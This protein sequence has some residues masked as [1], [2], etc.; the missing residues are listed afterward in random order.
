MGVN[1]QGGGDVGMAENLLDHLRRQAAGRHFGGGGVAAGVRCDALNAQLLHQ[2]AEGLAHVVVVPREAVPGC[3]EVRRAAGA[4]GKP[5]GDK[6]A[7]IGMDGNDAAA[8]H[9]GLFAA[10]EVAFRQVNIVP[11][12]GKQL[13]Q[14]HPRVDQHQRD[15]GGFAQAAVIGHA[16]DG[17][18]FGGGKHPRFGRAGGGEGQRRCI[19]GVDDVLVDGVLAQLAEQLALLFAQAA[20]AARV[21][22]LLD[23]GLV[24]LGFQLGNAAA[25]QRIG[26]V[27]GVLVR[28]LRRLA[29][30][31]VVQHAPA[32]VHVAEGVAQALRRGLAGVDAVQ[33]LHRVAR[34]G[35]RADAGA[36]GGDGNVRAVFVARVLPDGAG[37]ARAAVAA[38]LRGFAVRQ[39]LAAVAAQARVRRDAAPAARA[40][41]MQAPLPCR[42]AAPRGFLLLLMEAATEDFSAAAYFCPS[43]PLA[44]FFCSRWICLML[45][46]G[47][48][49]SSGMVPP[50]SAMVW[51]TLRPT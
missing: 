47:A 1:V 46:S 2:A 24:I 18:D 15:F 41:H 12:D 32:V 39:A 31:G 23:D 49:K 8:A 19:I 40:V 30:F 36:V 50:S 45:F 33:H 44:S 27:V 28:V 17:A 4:G 9:F 38:A 16:P 10:D 13:V 3:E 48:G 29:D 11:A 43:F 5:V 25:V 7:D 14:A 34:C 37:A 20:A 51:R 21:R 35:E 6:G 22:D 26:L 42:A